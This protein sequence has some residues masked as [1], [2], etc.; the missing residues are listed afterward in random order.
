[1][2]S[3]LPF[4]TL[5]LCCSALPLGAQQPASLSQAAQQAGYSIT[6]TGAHYRVWSRLQWA[7]NDAGAPYLLTNEF[8]EVATGLNRWVSNRWVEARPQLAVTSNGIVGAGAQH[9]VVFATNLNSTAAVQIRMSNGQWVR[10]NPLCLAY[11]DT[12]SGSNVYFALVQDSQPIILGSN[13]VVYPD[14]FSGA[15]ASIAYT[16]SRAGIAQDLRFHAKPPS[17]ESLGL[18]PATTHLLAITEITEAP[19]P[20]I[21]DSPWP[22]G[23]ETLQDQSITLGPMRLAHGRAFL[24]SA[25]NRKLGTPVAKA[26]LLADGR[27]FILE[28]LQWSRIR[29]DLL[30]LPD[31]E[32]NLVAAATNAAISSPARW[33]ASS[34]LPGAPS[35]KTPILSSLP[36]PALETASL[37]GNTGLSVA[38][39][40]PAG[41]IGVSAVPSRSQNIASCDQVSDDNSFILD[42]NLLN[43][44]GAPYLTCGMTAVVDGSY[45]ITQLGIQGGATVKFTPGSRL[46]L[47]GPFSWLGVGACND[48]GPAVFTSVKDNTVGDNTSD[49]GYGTDPQE[50]EYGAALQVNDCS[51]LQ[52]AQAHLEVRY[53]DPGIVSY[54]CTPTISVTA[55]DPLAVKGASPADPGT[56]TFTRQGGDWTYAQEIPFNLGGS[57]ASPTDYSPLGL[58]VT[59][60]AGQ[61]TAILTVT[62]SAATGAAF[63]RGYVNL[64]A[65]PDD[66]YNLATPSSAKVFIYDS[67]AAAPASLPAPSG[68]VVS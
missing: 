40:M 42:W 33:F 56:F 52:S 7:T 63:E 51:Y 1:M 60:P 18:S 68:L 27:R 48:G 59:I 9:A 65:L 54:T 25:P 23:L 24:A 16:F 46:E 6:A 58:S 8:R 30:G 14:A 36:E 49:L 12:S 35:H 11:H 15:A 62:P 66:S 20:Q 2:K 19:Q 43:D 44:G 47:D 31:S 34:S 3:S 32:T 26:W 67:T 38:S 28:R 21:Q 17:P 39:V 41:T 13:R 22:S 29:D 53:A 45:Y 4:F 37:H 61:G 5:A 10:A 57:T 64:T 55:S 50:G